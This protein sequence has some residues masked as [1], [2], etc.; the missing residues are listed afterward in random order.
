MKR[1]SWDHTRKGGIIK[2]IRGAPYPNFPRHIIFALFHFLANIS[3]PLTP[4]K[5]SVY[6]EKGFI[7]TVIEIAQKNEEPDILKVFISLGPMR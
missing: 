2:K 6:V 4:K 5:G 1:K 3:G 7:G